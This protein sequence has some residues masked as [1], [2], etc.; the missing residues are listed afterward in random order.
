[1]TLPGAIGPDL[2]LENSS[3]TEV[4]VKLR[5]ALAAVPPADSAEILPA[6]AAPTDS[7][8]I[9]P[10]PAA[11]AQTAAA[12][13]AIL[14]STGYADQYEIPDP[15]A[16][17]VPDVPRQLKPIVKPIIPRSRAE[18]CDGLT[19]AAYS[20]NLPAP[21]FIRL[22]YQ[23]SEFHPGAV[24]PA[25]A[26]GVAQ[27]MPETTAD[28]RLDNPYDPLQ[29]IKASASLL[30]DLAR[31]FG[32]LGLAAA[33][34]N[35]GPR[36]IEAWLAKKGKLPQETKDYVK[37]ITGRPAENW[38]AI[39]RGSPAVKLQRHAPCQEFAGLLAWDGPERIPLPPMRN[40][41]TRKAAKQPAP[42]LRGNVA[43]ALRAQVKIMRRG[44]QMTA[45]IDS[46]A[47]KSPALHGAAHATVQQAA[48]KQKH[49]SVELSQR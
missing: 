38:T 39:E 19:D 49:P 20:N 4:V 48:K 23:E 11:P 36:R 14:A 8:E 33:A 10:A 5:P 22:L 18:I 37:T 16:E 17:R 45:T 42:E 44:S 31:R 7:A 3:D 41:G 13:A 30:R 2:A 26:E 43:V 1:M 27:F 24:S 9:L 34:Y 15:V 46:G 35:A 29:A 6:P 32:N 40:A 25:G 12:S 21:F 47:A 28:R